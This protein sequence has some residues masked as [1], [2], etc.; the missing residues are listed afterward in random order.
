MP[1]DLMPTLPLTNTRYNFLADALRGEFNRVRSG[2]IATPSL[3]NEIGSVQT[4]DTPLGTDE[5]LQFAIAFKALASGRLALISDPADISPFHDSLF[6]Q[7]PDVVTIDKISYLSTAVNIRFGEGEGFTNT[8]NRFD[9]NND[10]FASPIDILLVINS[11]NT[12]GSRKL[13]GGSGGEGEDPGRR[14]FYD[15]NGD[16]FLSPADAL[17]VINH[18]NNRG[19]NA[20]GEGEGKA[21]VKPWA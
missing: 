17:M 10:G 12:S 21:K 15:V 3:I 11:L 8:T 6:F 5:Q 20:G 18:L 4:N 1:L 2:D 9:V 19:A 14:Y 16:G 13:Q 7:P